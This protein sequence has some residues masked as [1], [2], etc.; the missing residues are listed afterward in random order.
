MCKLDSPETSY[1]NSTNN[2]T[3][4]T[5]TTTNNNNNNIITNQIFYFCNWKIC[6]NIFIFAELSLYQQTSLFRELL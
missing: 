6:S 2:T 1:K 3:T 5:T 4:T